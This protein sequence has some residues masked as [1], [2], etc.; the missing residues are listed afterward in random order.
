MYKFNCPTKLGR[1]LSVSL[2][3]AATTY[4]VTVLCHTLLLN[5]LYQFDLHSTDY[6]TI[7]LAFISVSLRSHTSSYS[8]AHSSNFWGLGRLYPPRSLTWHVDEIICGCEVFVFQPPRS[9]PALS[10]VTVSVFFI[11]EA[12]ISYNWTHVF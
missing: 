10:P 2:H 7:S 1:H 4:S 3:P 8:H 6:F 11:Q 5:L 12:L 9:S